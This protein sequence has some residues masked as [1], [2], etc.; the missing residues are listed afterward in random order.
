MKVT[1]FCLRVKIVVALVISKTAKKVARVV[2][3]RAK[4][5]HLAFLLEA[6]HHPVVP[7]LGARVEHLDCPETMDEISHA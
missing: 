3:N 5:A 7:S 6:A 4:V 2:E 1:R